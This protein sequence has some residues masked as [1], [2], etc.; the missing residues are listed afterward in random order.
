MIFDQPHEQKKIHPGHHNMFFHVFFLNVFVRVSYQ[1]SPKKA[2]P[3]SI[4]ITPGHPAA[5]AA[6]QALAPLAPPWDAQQLGRGDRHR[7]HLPRQPLGLEADRGLRGKRAAKLR[8]GPRG[9]GG[10]TFGSHGKM[11]GIRIS[12]WFFGLIFWTRIWVDGWHGMDCSCLD[13]ESDFKMESFAHHPNKRAFV[14]WFDFEILNTNVYSSGL[15]SYIK[16][17]KT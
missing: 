14:E 17:Y 11:L 15:G 4:S 16:Q 8:G 1:F 7:G 13:W 12:W 9:C 3:R 5:G 2:W 6:V 10:S